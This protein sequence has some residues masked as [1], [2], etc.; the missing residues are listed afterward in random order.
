MNTNPNA[1][2]ILCYGDSNTWGHIPITKERYSA[3]VRW[4]GLLQSKLG[5]DYEIIEEGLG[6]R[7]TRWEYSEKEGRN[8]KMYLLPCL[9]SHNPIDVIILFL[10]TNDLKEVYQQTAQQIATSIRELI[11]IIKKKSL[12]KQKV[13]PMILLISPAIVDETVPG[14]EERYKGAQ[15]RSEGLGIEYAKVAKEE[16]CKFVDL[17]AIV[18]PSKQDGI[19]FEPEAHLLIADTFEKSLREMLK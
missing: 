11:Q 6:S 15:Q 2:R 18:R 19:H 14:T 10:G 8:G 16:G 1:I 4:T 12:T 17:A 3:D 7:T 5:G 13:V 9:E